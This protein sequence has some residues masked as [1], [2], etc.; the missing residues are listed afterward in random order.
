MVMGRRLVVM[1]FA[2][3]TGIDLRAAQQPHMLH[4][5]NLDF[6]YP[7]CTNTHTDTHTAANS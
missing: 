5:C 2:A 4:L 6:G 3:A 1:P 7:I